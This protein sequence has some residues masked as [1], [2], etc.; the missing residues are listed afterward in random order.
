MFPS[1]PY[2]SVYH[3]SG[4]ANLNGISFSVLVPI[5]LLWVAAEVLRLTYHVAFLS[6]IVLLFE[7]I[8]RFFQVIRW[9][10]SKRDANFLCIA[11]AFSDKEDTT[12][13]TVAV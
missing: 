1:L 11:V 5:L 2:N 6:S 9:R 13:K 12:S 8:L 10:G 3:I 7:S 4:Q